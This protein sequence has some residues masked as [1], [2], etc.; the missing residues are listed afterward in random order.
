MLRHPA[1]RLTA[2]TLIAAGLA[3]AAHGCGGDDNKNPTGPGGGGTAAD[4]TIS[5]VGNSGSSSFSPNPD[6]VSVGQTVSW[7]NNDGS[8]THTSTAD[9]SSWNTG[10]ISPG[11]TSTPITMNNAGSFPYHCG[12]HPSMVGTLVVIP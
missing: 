7:K 2:I 8:M 10:N 3:F 9:G 12:L 1:L 6:T 11:A 5:I 4:V